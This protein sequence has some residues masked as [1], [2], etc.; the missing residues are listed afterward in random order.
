MGKR[1][2]NLGKYMSGLV[3]NFEK[4]LDYHDKRTFHGGHDGIGTI[5][6]YFW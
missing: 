1:I 6:K 3:A 5:S 4:Y 2:S